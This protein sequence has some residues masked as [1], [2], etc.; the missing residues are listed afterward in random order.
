M[1]SHAGMPNKGWTYTGDDKGDILINGEG[2]EGQDEKVLG[3]CWNPKS[4]IFKFCVALCFKS[5]KCPDIH[6][7][8]LEELLKIPI[9]LITRRSM[10][11]NVHRIFDSLGLVLPTLLQ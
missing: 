4:D 5:K 11:S 8:T 9:E 7:S 3:Y 1:L 10:L 2:D 6:V